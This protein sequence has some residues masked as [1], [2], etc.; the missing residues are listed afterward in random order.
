MV[1]FKTWMEFV[2]RRTRDPRFFAFL[3]TVLF[4]LSFL[5]R[6]K[7]FE[8]IDSKL[9]D[10]LFT[11]R[12]PIK[13]QGN[14]VIAAIDESSIEKLGRWPWSRDKFASLVRR[15]SDL[16]AAVIA[17]DVIF[18]EPEANDASFAKSIKDAGNVIFPVV[19]LF[20]RE[21]SSHLDS[22]LEPLP[23]SKKKD[24]SKL[25]FLSGKRC[26]F[27]V[28]PLVSEA[29][30][31]GHINIFP[32][33]D[34]TVRRE[35]L[36]IEYAGMI[37]PSFSLKVASYF[38][39]IPKEK[40]V[41]DA[42]E[43]IRLGKRFIPTS[44]LGSILIP[45]YGG[46]ETFRYIPIV[47]IIEGKVKKEEIE[48]K[49]VLVGAV[50]VGIY[51]LRVTPVS[52]ALPGVEKHA[53]VIASII[54]ERYL[55]EAPAYLVI[56]ILTLSGIFGLL[57]FG[58]LKAAH[59]LLML[60]LLIFSYFFA[61]YV[62][63]KY[64][65]LWLSQFYLYGNTISQFILISVVRYALSEKEAKRIRK[66]F[67]NYVTE[68]VVNE[69]VKNPALLRLGGERREVTVLF[70]DIRG[71]TSFSEKVSPEEVVNTLNEYFAKMTDVIF[72]WEG[73]L[74]K[75][76]GD[77]IMVFWNAPL[78]QDDHAMRAVACALEMSEG[79]KDLCRKWESEKKPK[80]RI[81]IGINTGEVLVGNIGAEGKKM[82]YTVIGDHVNLASRLEG[83]NRRFESEIIISE[84]V[85]EKVRDQILS[86]SLGPVLVR[87][88]GRIVVKGKERP[89]KIYSVQQGSDAA[90]RIEEADANDVMVMTEK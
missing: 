16:G 21:E 52:P 58:K 26:L 40:I 39:G 1:K 48:E 27:P 79:L 50:A 7:I 31:L 71:F 2:K 43:G 32:D 87:G 77:A 5:F 65:G 44:G 69:L 41:I 45:Y 34:G 64:Y 28:E 68:R 8:T 73:T 83:L 59:S 22:F 6:P 78:K 80:L 55:K 90:P 54:E 75:F 10:L 38:L 3:I 37:I 29:S 15:L 23:I 12:G 61:S 46:N 66:I 53:N 62:L 33:P 18:S 13:H 86:G 89:V 57:L 30:G 70:S 72:K 4:I 76:M 25:K 84:F 60:I 35:F 42:K 19:F 74:D 11:M 24:I 56:S 63:F 14:I 81:G 82:D 36:Y 85:L 49:I 88:L 17:F 67:S 47:D 9:Y 20:D 51:D